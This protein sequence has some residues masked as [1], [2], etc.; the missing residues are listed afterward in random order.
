MKP[1]YKMTN[2]D[3]FDKFIS[4]EIPDDKRY[5]ELY[6]MVA[7]RMMNGPCGNKNPKCLCMVDGKC[8]FHYPRSFSSKIMQGHDGYPI[9]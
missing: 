8:R 7:K 3:E 9:Y 5:P 2:P 1:W 4:A 6:E